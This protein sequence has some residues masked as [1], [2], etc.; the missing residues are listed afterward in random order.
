MVNN[1]KLVQDN[2]CFNTFFKKTV[3]YGHLKIVEKRNTVKI[4]D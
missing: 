3:S 2:Q 4:R 1:R